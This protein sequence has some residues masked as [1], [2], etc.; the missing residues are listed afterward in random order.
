MRRCAKKGF[1]QLRLLPRRLN[2]WSIPG[3]DLVRFFSPHAYR[4]PWG[5]VYS[6]FVGVEIPALREWLNTHAPGEKVGIFHTC[7]TGYVIANE[8][9]LND[10]MVEHGDPVPADLWA[11]LLMDRILRIPDSL[12]ALVR[13]YR[14][15]RQQLGFLAHPYDKPA[16]DFLLKWRENPDPALHVPRMLPTGQIV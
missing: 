13:V 6:G 3:Q 14:S 9:V 16:W 15:D 1:N 2:V 5:F 10:F 4:R 7:F 8:D 12:D 11:G